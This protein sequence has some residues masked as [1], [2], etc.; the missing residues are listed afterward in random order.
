[1]HEPY[2]PLGNADVQ[3]LLH[4]KSGVKHISWLYFNPGDDAVLGDDKKITADEKKELK[5]VGL[6]VISYQ[7]LHLVP[8]NP[9]KVRREDQK[10]KLKKIKEQQK[11]GDLSYLLNRRRK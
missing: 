2:A 4:T 7:D 5:S 8:E 11:P 6:F 10:T 9:G 3:T 1:L